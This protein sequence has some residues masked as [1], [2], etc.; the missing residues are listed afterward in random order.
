MR[1]RSSYASVYVPSPL[2]VG[3]ELTRFARPICGDSVNVTL[4]GVLSSPG[5]P[6]P[7][8]SEDAPS[9]L[10]SD[11]GTPPALVALEIAVFRYGPRFVPGVTVTV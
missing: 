4:V 3:P 7:L 6:L 5:S 9:V 10:E 8:A 1:T 11:S 2:L